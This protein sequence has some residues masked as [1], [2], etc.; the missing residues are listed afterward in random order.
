L[1]SAAPSTRRGPQHERDAAR[2]R[3]LLDTGLEVFGTDGYAGSAIEDLCARAGVGTRSFYVDFPSKEDLLL[4][5]YDRH[6]AEVGVTLQAALDRE[7]RDLA[8]YVRHGVTTYVTAALADERSARVQMVEIV[9]VS[10]RC[11]RHRREVLRAFAGQVHAAGERMRRAGL[12]PRGLD[13]LVSMALVGASNELLIDWLATPARRRP[14]RR[15][16]VDA[17]TQVYLGTA[18]TG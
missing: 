4:A 3:R 16:V 8:A 7:P 12:A 17:L 1:S 10:E 5:V 2:R 18:G 13:P 11:E 6:I 9:G 14:S 15:K